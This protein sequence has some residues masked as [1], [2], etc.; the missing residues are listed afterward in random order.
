MES[1]TDPQIEETSALQLNIERLA[2]K[3]M[4]SELNAR[5]LQ[6]CIDQQCVP[7][8]LRLKLKLYIGND[9]ED[10]QQSIDVL[11]KKVSLE[12]C[13]RVKI[14]HKNKS[15]KVGE[16][17]EKHREELKKQPDFDISNFDQKVYEK[18][19][20]KKNII[21]ER[22]NKK[23]K[24][25][26]EKTILQ[27]QIQNKTSKVSRKP[28]RS[29][30][31]KIN[32]K[33]DNDS[34]NQTEQKQSSQNTQPDTH[35]SRA[36]RFQGI[37]KKI[38]GYAKKSTTTVPPTSKNLNVPGTKK[39]TYAEALTKGTPK[40]TMHEVLTTIQR[41]LETNNIQANIETE[42]SSKKRTKTN[43]DEKRKYYNKSKKDRKR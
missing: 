17:M 41:F 29:K 31:G 39:T 36:P 9:C 5:F 37:N 21:L 1:T 30:A 10:V 15:I 26:C 32:K 18:T 34:T 16:E 27:P 23:L 28:T 20:M 14:G 43:G 12:I 2:E 4:K 35:S 11:L 3:Q 24:N 38:K 22:Q 42:D 7:Q 25:L 19:E 13:E 6:N 40:I 33:T 8:G